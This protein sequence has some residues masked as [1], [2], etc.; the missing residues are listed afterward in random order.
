MIISC[1]S[2]GSIQSDMGGELVGMGPVGIA[3]NFL[4]GHVPLVN[5]SILRLWSMVLKYSE[6]VLWS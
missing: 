2:Q 6:T 5:F 4:E 1:R 3:H